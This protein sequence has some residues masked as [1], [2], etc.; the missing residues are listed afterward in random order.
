MSS[1]TGGAEAYR[2]ENLRVILASLVICLAALSGYG[3]VF[4]DEL[5][6]IRLA[7]VLSDFRFDQEGFA[8]L[9]I[10]LISACVFGMS[11]SRSDLELQE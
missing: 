10:L 2:R 7:I 3:A 6:Q 8:C 11:C 4:I 1:G 9:F 5:H